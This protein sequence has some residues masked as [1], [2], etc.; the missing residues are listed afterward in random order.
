[1]P[2]DAALFHKLVFVTILVRDQEEALRYYTQ[3]LGF[4]KRKDILREGSRWLTVAPPGQ[5]EVEV[6]LQET[7]WALHGGV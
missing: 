1:M 4:E 7:G 3:V 6:V 2:T 5:T